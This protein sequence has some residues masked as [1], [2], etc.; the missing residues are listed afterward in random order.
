VGLCHSYTL[1]A[2][3]VGVMD[4]G[5]A[6]FHPE[7]ARPASVISRERRGAGMSYFIVGANV[8]YA[9]GPLIATRSY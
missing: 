7:A 6:V 5:V 9:L 4:F 3:S 1:V 2:V 8:G